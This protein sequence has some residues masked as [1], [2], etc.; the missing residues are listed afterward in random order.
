MIKLKAGVDIKGIKAE[1]V[2]G[3]VIVDSVFEDKGVYETIVT[4]VKDGKHKPGSLHYSGLA[5]DFRSKH[6]SGLVLKNA[7]V[8][9]I[10]S[11][12]GDQWDVLLEHLGKPNE[13][14]HVEFD[15]K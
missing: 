10:K 2:F 15:P 13:H 5:A 7:I 3:I 11:S 1:M 4:S 14:I 8:E 6:I 9:S 12:L